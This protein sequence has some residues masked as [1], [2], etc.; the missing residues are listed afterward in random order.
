MRK[1][2]V[3]YCTCVACG[4]VL[5]VSDNF[6]GAANS[7]GDVCAN[8][9]L[10]F[11]Y[12]DNGSGS[13]SGRSQAANGFQWRSEGTK[14]AKER[15]LEDMKMVK[16][17]ETCT[18][19][20]DRLTAA[21]Q[22]HTALCFFDPPAMRNTPEFAQYRC[23]VMPKMPARAGALQ[24]SASEGAANN[25]EGA[26]SSV[27]NASNGDATESQPTRPPAAACAA[28]ADAPPAR[29]LPVA[30]RTALAAQ[31]AAQAARSRAPSA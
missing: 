10:E 15:R 20:L 30:D 29:A 7:S 13:G 23:A 5:R 19:A 3:A 1:A 14:A 27:K 11:S 17:M 26:E 16:Q 2:K 24:D 31:A 28:T 9:D 4:R 12:D 18:Q 6:S 25:S 21:Q 8:V 22:E